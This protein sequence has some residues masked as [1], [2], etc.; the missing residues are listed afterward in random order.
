MVLYLLRL[1]ATHHAF[2]NKACFS[3]RK[4]LHYNRVFV[5]N[6]ATQ[7]RLISIDRI[8]NIN[9]DLLLCDF[10][11]KLAR[12]KHSLEEICNTIKAQENLLECGNIHNGKLHHGFGCDPHVD[13]WGNTGCL[14]ERKQDLERHVARCTSNLA[15]FEY[16]WES[17][18]TERSRD[19]FES[20]GLIHS[21]R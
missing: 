1:L 10:V 19:V 21:Y 5:A 7:A 13:D 18:H 9:V 16:G 15:A 6:Q 11:E 12:S 20:L 2:E 14:I 3:N 4:D 17:K 8:G